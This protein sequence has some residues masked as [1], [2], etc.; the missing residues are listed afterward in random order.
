VLLGKWLEARAK[1]Q[2][3]DAIRALEALRPATALVVDNGVERE[4]PLAEVNVGDLIRVRPGAR[5]PVDGEV[6]EGASHLDESLLTGESLP[7]A[8]GT[9]DKVT[10]GAL[11]GEGLLTVRTTAVGGETALARIVRLVEN[12]QAK[13]APIQRLVDRVSAVFVPVV[14]GIALV[15]LLGWGLGAGDWTAALLNAVAVLVIACPCALGLATPAAIMAGTGVAARH[16]ILIKD[17]EALELAHRVRIVAFDKTG[18]LTVGRPRLAAIEAVPGDTTEAAHRA[19]AA[20]Q[21]GSEHPLA[22][23]VLEALPAGTAPPATTRLRA[24]PGRGL[25]AAVDGVDHALGST[26][27]MQE[28]KVPLDKLAARAEALQAQG[29]TVSWLAALEATGPRLR[30]LLAFAD[31]PKPEAAAALARLHA[32][33]LRTALVTGDNAG[34]ARGVAAA[35]GIDD[36]RAEVLPGDKARIVGELRDAASTAA[37]SGASRPLVAMVG[38]GINDAPAL[39]AADVG[40][41]MAAPGQGTDVAMHAAGITLLRGDVQLVPDALDLARRTAAKIRGNLFWAFAFNAIGIP[42]AAFGQLS[43]VIAGGAMAFSS[44]FV[45]SNALLLTRWRRPAR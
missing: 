30:A 22:R 39:A 7:V 11:N 41:A 10:G 3:T 33:G 21:Q 38:D 36:V 31:T 28:L 25:R 20:L 29:H 18:T 13:K 9:G 44:F 43:P 23:A 14:L 42:L 27:W 8:R 24:V 35:L 15:T 26:R 34:A 6:V 2:A 12:A 16:G 4:R 5:V 45:V 17:A 37:S 19:A 40:I 1:R 32:S